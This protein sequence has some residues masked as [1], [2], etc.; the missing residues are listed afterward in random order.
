MPILETSG[1][2]KDY[3]SLRALDDL[4]LAVQ[5]GEIFGL[6]GPNGA[7]KT[8]AISMIC[9][10]L[11]PSRGTVRIDGHDMAHETARAKRK[12]GLVPQE[13]ALYDDLDA[14]QNL[15]YFGR[16]HGIQGATLTRRIGDCLE[17]AGLTDRA[18]EPVR[19]FSG[20]MKRRLNIAIG[21]LHEPHLLVL[22]EPTVGV[23]PQ[24][25]AHIFDTVRTLNRELD[26]TVLYTS[27]YMEEV[28]ALCQR[29]AILDHGKC[30]VLD[31]VDDL[32]RAHSNARL[33]IAIEGDLE[34]AHAALN[35][36]AT[37]QVDQGRLVVRA[38]DSVAEAA[39]VLEDCGVRITS[40][41]S[42]QANLESVFL[43]LTGRSL[44][45]AP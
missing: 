14:R 43:D 27:H 45:D 21:M 2:A 44:R 15:T 11:T 35:Q 7:G 31:D 41:R 1:L 37:T 25:R 30:V 3:G 26:M 29:V 36:V 32:I 34:T 38:L 4:D 28:E 17:V 16:L 18:N 22:D 13:L 6:L 9:G 5:A 23:D 8:T 12:L 42:T 10:A 20:G 40:L 33:E 39:R 19:R 24:S